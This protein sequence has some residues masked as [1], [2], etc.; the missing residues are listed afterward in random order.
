TAWLGDQWLVD[1]GLAPGDRVIVDGLQRV[2]PGAA[3]RPVAAPATGGPSA[4]SQPTDVSKPA[5]T[6]KPAAGVERRG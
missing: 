1:Q 3:V 2:M 6:P 5:D 4:V